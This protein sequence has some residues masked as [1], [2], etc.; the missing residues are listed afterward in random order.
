M[1]S[2]SKKSEGLKTTQMNDG[3][4]EEENRDLTGFWEKVS[5][6]WYVSIFNVSGTL[7]LI[8]LWIIYT[9]IFMPFG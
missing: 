8:T 1:K 6:I 3:R 5:N 9:H 7:E 4:E 2:S